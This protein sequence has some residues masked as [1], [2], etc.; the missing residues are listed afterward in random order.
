[1]GREYFGGKA[2]RKQ[3]LGAKLDRATADMPQGAASAI[4][5]ILNGKV[6]ITT[7]VG[8]VTVAI[9]GANATKLVANPT[10]ST[11]A[12]TDLCAT[13]DINTCDIGDLLGITGTPGDNLL[14][15]HKGSI[16]AMLTGGVILQTGTLDLDCAGSVTGK[17]KWLI[18]YIPLDDGAEVTVA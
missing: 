10:L 4:F 3:I 8:E 16:Q 6:L 14:V 7:I 18:T 5:N 11:A 17:I 9:G 1:M 15:A 13:T 2:R 12:D